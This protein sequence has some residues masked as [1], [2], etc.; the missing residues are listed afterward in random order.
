MNT[1]TPVAEGKAAPIESAGSRIVSLLR[2]A[3][4]AVRA[5]RSE[6]R[7]RL[8]EMLSLGEKRFVAVVEYGAEKFILAGTPQRISLL[9]KLARN[10][11]AEA[12]RELLGSQEAPSERLEKR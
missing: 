11:A 10:A 3:V 1:F 2:R 9:T 6:R 7:L 12:S 8:C 4:S 5:R